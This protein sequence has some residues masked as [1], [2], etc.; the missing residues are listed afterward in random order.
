MDDPDTP[1][2]GRIGQLSVLKRVLLTAYRTMCFV[3]M[4]PVPAE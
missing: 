2:S 1:L 4:N 3:R